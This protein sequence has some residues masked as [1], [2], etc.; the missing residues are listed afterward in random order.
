MLDVPLVAGESVE[1]RF[2]LP[3]SGRVLTTTA[4]VRWSRAA[5]L[6]HA[7][8]VELNGLSSEALEDIRRFVALTGV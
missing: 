8:G 4:T 5:R 6:R 1:L 7:T 2:C 3:V